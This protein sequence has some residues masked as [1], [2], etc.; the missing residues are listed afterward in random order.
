MAVIPLV[1]ARKEAQTLAAALAQP[2]QEPRTSPRPDKL[3]TWRVVRTE[4]MR[5]WLRSGDL[6]AM[7]PLPVGGARWGDLVVFSS[8]DREYCHRTLWR[9]LT[10]GD[11]AVVFDRRHA[12]YFARVVAVHRDGRVFRLDTCAA[13]W[14]G[15][16]TALVSFCI[17]LA[18]G[19]QVRR[20]GRQP[21]ATKPVGWRK[22]LRYG[23]E[24]VNHL[25][26]AAI[27]RAWRRCATFDEEADGA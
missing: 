22:A 17:G 25:L 7:E 5:P 11:S 13:R 4:S 16:A 8:S 19:W 3:A 24:R 21:C 2:P 9:T 18:G 20:Q 6:V 14:A 10:K 12:P 26:L 23:L 27:W 15:R 1:K